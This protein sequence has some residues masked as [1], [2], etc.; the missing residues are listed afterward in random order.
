MVMTPVCYRGT[1]CWKIIKSL[2]EIGVA[3]AGFLLRA[4]FSPLAATSFTPLF[5]GR[6]YLMAA[7]RGVRLLRQ[8]S[9]HQR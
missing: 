7:L 9:L 1:S 3:A 4:Q 6:E 2:E 8:C 5:V